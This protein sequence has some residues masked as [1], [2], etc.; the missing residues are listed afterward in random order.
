MLSLIGKRKEE[1]GEK[2][3]GVIFF[4]FFLPKKNFRLNNLIHGLGKGAKNNL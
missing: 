1:E 4:V 2:G 3:A